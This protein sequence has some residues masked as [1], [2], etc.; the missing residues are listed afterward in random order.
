[1]S[2]SIYNSTI[3]PLQN[4]QSFIGTYYDNIIDFSEINISIFCDTGYELTFYFSQDKINTNYT[5]SQSVAY[6]ANT[7]FFRV[8]PLERYFKI[9]ITATDGNMSVLNIQTKYKSNITYQ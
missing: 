1:M 8:P 6:S 5:E 4:S 2:L 7:L 9:G 3:V